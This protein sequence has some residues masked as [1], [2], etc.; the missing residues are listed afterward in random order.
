MLEILKVADLLAENRYKTVRFHDR[1]RL[2]HIGDNGNANGLRNLGLDDIDELLGK[3]ARQINAKNLSSANMAS[4]SY[5]VGLHGVGAA[6]PHLEQIIRPRRELTHNK[7]EGR[8][9][10]LFYIIEIRAVALFPARIVH[11]A[12][13]HAARKVQ[14][15]IRRITFQPALYL[16]DLGGHL[17]IGL[18]RLLKR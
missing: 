18:L 12:V 6:Y 1:Q 11:I 10:I 2:I 8:A 17:R 5:G 7:L 14:G 3:G 15:A 9:L 16:P 13:I 4:H